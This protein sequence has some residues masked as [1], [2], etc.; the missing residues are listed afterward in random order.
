VSDQDAVKINRMLPAPIAE[1]FDW[2]T[3]ADKLRE[4]MSPV[5]MAEATVDLRIGGKF[6]IVMRSGDVAID[7][8]G[9]FLE[10]E[11]PR[12]LVFTWVSPFTGPE[13]SLVTVELEPDGDDATRLRLIHSKLPQAIAA[14][15]RDGWGT[16]LERLATNL[17]ADDGE[18][19]RWRSTS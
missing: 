8:T 1:V 19:A 5:G 12:R 9:E 10:I 7:H 13:P 17:R 15:H 2:W 3:Q 6:R 18:G 4:W 16:M 14:S 11:V